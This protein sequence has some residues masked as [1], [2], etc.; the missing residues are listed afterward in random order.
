VGLVLIIW[1]YGHYRAAGMIPVWYPPHGMR[2]LTYLLVL[3]AFIL[4]ASAHAPSHIR[5]WVKHPMILG[6]VL[7]SLGHLLVRGDLGS[8]ILFGA[9]LAWGVV[10]RLSMASRAPGDIQGPK[11]VGVPRWGADIVSVVA[12]VA[13]YLAFM[14]WLHPLL[15][16]VPVVGG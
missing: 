7:W 3:V 13:V 4:L 12:G 8:M 15:I 16:G 2:H 6:V 5:A 11:P 10:A 1:G 9:F 14:F